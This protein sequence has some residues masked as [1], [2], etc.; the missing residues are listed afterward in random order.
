MISET[1]TLSQII[2]A[3][4]G[5]VFF[6]PSIVD[7]E[8]P[9]GSLS[10]D[11][12]TIAKG[13]IFIALRGENFDGHH[14]LAT[15]VERNASCLVVEELMQNAPPQ[16]AQ[17]LVKDTLKALGDIAQYW[18]RQ[19]STIPLLCI[20]GSVGKTTT[21]EML[22]HIISTKLNT[23]G[24]TG[25][26]NNLIGAPMMLSRLCSEHQAAVLELG[27]NAPGELKRLIEIAQPNAVLLTNIRDAHIGNFA[28]QDELYYAKCECLRW[29]PPNTTFIIC[30]DDKLSQRALKQYGHGHKIILFGCSE[31]AM[32]RAENIAPLSPFGYSFDLVISNQSRK[33]VALHHFGKGHIYNALGAAAGAVF[34]GEKSNTIAARLSCFEADAARCEVELMPDGWFCI[35]DYYNASP[36]AT[37]NSLRSMKDFNIT[38]RRFALLGD[39]REL[40][41]MSPM[42]HEQ[43]GKIAAQCDLEH[44]HVFGEESKMI[45]EG[46]R[47]AG[48]TNVTHHATYEDAAAALHEQLR[49]DDL[50]LIK[51][52]RLI[53]LERV[54]EMLKNDFSNVDDIK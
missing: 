44:L 19:H 30:A 17:V 22:L 14:F 3:T 20:A 37:E 35:K 4:S 15:A 50:L 53:H 7:Q 24:T 51:A 48:M 36:T 12:R 43:L 34:F 52:S 9:L 54:Y 46:A 33:V 21:K 47:K 31:T 27:M 32:I 18:R 25:N 42:Y 8:S 5:T 2:E 39:L 38:G 28:S 16:V 26:L 23:L 40:G 49:R 13:D 41:K 10:T 6:D 45:A 11:T 1:M 29:A